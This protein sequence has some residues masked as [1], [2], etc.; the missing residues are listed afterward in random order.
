[1]G[2]DDSTI[3][4]TRAACTCNHASRSNDGG[5]TTGGVETLL[6]APLGLLVVFMNG[7]RLICEP[8]HAIWMPLQPLRKFRDTSMKFWA[9]KLREIV[10]DVLEHAPIKV[11]IVAPCFIHFVLRYIGQPTGR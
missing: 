11:R 3:R 10:H 7:L 8:L 5:S 2:S 1:M 9:F 6:C 4:R